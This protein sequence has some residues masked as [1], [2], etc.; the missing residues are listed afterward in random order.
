MYQRGDLALLLRIWGLTLLFHADDGIC[1]R[2]FWAFLRQ[3]PC[4]FGVAVSDSLGRH[5]YRVQQRPALVVLVK[6][7]DRTSTSAAGFV[8]P[9][10]RALTGRACCSNRSTGKHVLIAASTCASSRSSSLQIT[11]SPT[12]HAFASLRLAEVCFDVQDRRNQVSH[13]DLRRDYR[14]PE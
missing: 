10:A 3:S 11:I 14:H 2:T 7:A 5:S 1:G 9:R 6:A 12:V 8:E 4:V 13:G